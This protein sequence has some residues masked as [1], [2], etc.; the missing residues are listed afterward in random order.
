MRTWLHL[1]TVGVIVLA[2]VGCSRPARTVV[3]VDR[4]PCPPVKLEV[5]CPVTPTPIVGETWEDFSDRVKVWGV[6]CKA[7]ISAWEEAHAFC[8]GEYEEVSLFTLCWFISLGG[9]H[10]PCQ[11]PPLRWRIF[12]G[13]T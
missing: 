10:T 11:P 1:F 3:K 7:A 5:S 4:V 13:D 8:V 9:W 12:D 2:V 6:T